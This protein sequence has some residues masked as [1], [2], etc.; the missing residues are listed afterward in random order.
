MN[1]VPRIIDLF[2]A[3]PVEFTAEIEEAR[4]AFIPK[5]QAAV[6]GNNDL[7]TQSHSLDALRNV[8]FWQKQAGL[9][10]IDTPANGLD[11]AT[12]RAALCAEL[13]IEGVSLPE[14]MQVGYPH[15]LDFRLLMKFSD[16]TTLDVACAVSITATNATLDNPTGFTDPFGHYTT[17]I[18]AT[19][20]DAVTVTIT[21]SVILPGE[22][23]PSLIAETFLLVS[24]NGLDFDGTFA[25]WGGYFDGVNANPVVVTISQIQNGILGTFTSNV[26]GNEH[27]G[28]FSGTLSGE[29]LLNGSVTLD[30]ADGP[31]PMT[32]SQFTRR[33]DGFL[34]IQ[35]LWTATDCHGHAAAR[36]TACG[37]D[38]A[39][40]LDAGDTYGGFVVD[41]DSDGRTGISG[42]IAQSG[43]QINGSFTGEGGTFEFTGTL[44]PASNVVDIISA[45]AGGCAVESSDI[46]GTITASGTVGV[47]IWANRPRI[48]AWSSQMG[49]DILNVAGGTPFTC[50]QAP[51][52]GTL[53]RP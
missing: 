26:P 34:N 33:I 28:S 18:T 27:T 17:V 15:S 23:V 9:L 8:V 45:S 25:S 30:C 1:E 39:L 53:G 11:E 44:Q 41:Y 12:V 42:S 16:G 47:R 49:T 19:G 40:F 43:T 14:N 32:A 50:G 29:E 24:S 48:C 6:T 36:I 10:S 3:V 22:S 13:V 20:N 51:T 4:E 38:G 31:V 37:P 35:F 46:R 5:L 21:G 7:C 2:F 52:R